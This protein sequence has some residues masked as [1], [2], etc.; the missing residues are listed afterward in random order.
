M[1]ADRH[2]HKPTHTQTDKPVGCQLDWR[3]A[4]EAKD[5][6]Q[7]ADELMDRESGNMFWS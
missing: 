1:L 2:T 7:I 5:G 4:D 3:K 6:D